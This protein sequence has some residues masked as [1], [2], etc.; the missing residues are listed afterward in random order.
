MVSIYLRLRK[1]ELQREADRLEA[2]KAVAGCAAMA[3]HNARAAEVR[4]LHG[5][6]L[7]NVQKHARALRHAANLLNPG[8]AKSLAPLTCVSASNTNDT[9][10]FA[11]PRLI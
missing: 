7:E 6:Q 1:E 10:R 5:E 9:G 3:E 4:G 11:K 2:A 8:Q